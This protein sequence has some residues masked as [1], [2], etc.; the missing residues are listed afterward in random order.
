MTFWHSLYP[1]LPLQD[2]WA[3]TFLEIL[4]LVSG[5]QKLNLHSSR[6]T[7][8]GELPRNQQAMNSVHILS[9]QHVCADSVV[10]YEAY[11]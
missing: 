7:R 10:Q 3:E 4:N 9:E 8:A 6:V 11:R 5:C 2:I 1:L